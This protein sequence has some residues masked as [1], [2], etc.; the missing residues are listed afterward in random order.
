MR[1]SA[2]VSGSSTKVRPEAAERAFAQP[3]PTRPSDSRRLWLVSRWLRRRPSG[4]HDCSDLRVRTQPRRLHLVG[5]RPAARR[6]QAVRVRPGDPAADGAAPARLR[7]GADQGRGARAATRSW[8]ARS[9]TSSRCCSARRASSS[10]TPRRST[11]PSS[12]TTRTTS[13]T[14]C[15]P[16]SPASRRAPGT[17]STSSTSTPRSTGS[18]SSNLLYLVVSK[19]G[20][21]DLH[22]DAVSNLEMGYLYEELIRRFSELS[23]ETAGEHFT[24]ARGHPADGEPAVHRGRRPAR[25]SRGSSRRCSTRPA[26][27]GGMLSVA[28]DHLRAL[29]PAGPAGGVRAGAERRDVRHLPLRHDA[30]GPGRLA[31]RLRQLLHRGRPPGGRF[32]YLLANPPFGVEWKKVERRRPGRARDEG[33]RRPVRRRACRGSTTA[34]SCSCST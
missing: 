32:D 21:I 3:C 7:A 10:S 14:T 13:P 26:A 12:S 22:P 16:T 1:S 4:S 27:P 30:Q 11:S 20:E 18:T 23:N 28:E 15:A 25:P 24:P 6:L 31:H 33:L 19:F 5:R 34:A 9:R 29:Q 8:R 2:P 17:C